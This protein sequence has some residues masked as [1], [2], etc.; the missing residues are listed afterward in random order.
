MK[1]IGTTNKSLDGGCGKCRQFVIEWNT[2]PCHPTLLCAQESIIIELIG[3]LI[4]CSLLKDLSPYFLVIVLP[5]GVFF[6]SVAKKAPLRRYLRVWKK[7]SSQLD[8]YLSIIQR[9]IIA[10]LDGIAGETERQRRW[11]VFTSV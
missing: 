3:H 5:I 7:V 9:G 2:Y 1:F 4:V 8:M 11:R 6:T 10:K